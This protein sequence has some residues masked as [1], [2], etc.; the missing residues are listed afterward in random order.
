MPRLFSEARIDIDLDKQHPCWASVRLL[1]IIHLANYLGLRIILQKS[2]HGIHVRVLI[3]GREDRWLIMKLRALM[4]DDYDRYMYDIGRICRGTFMFNNL[5][6]W[7]RK[8]FE[9]HGA[10]EEPLRNL[11]QLLDE[12]T[13]KCI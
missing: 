1:K 11:E 10:R 6:N 7:R 3:P 13:I 8:Y 9:K 4:N 2:R 5:F 12:L